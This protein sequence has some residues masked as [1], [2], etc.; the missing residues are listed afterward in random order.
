MRFGMLLNRGN[1]T[2]NLIFLLKPCKCHTKISL[3]VFLF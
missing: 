1:D 3:N 2:K